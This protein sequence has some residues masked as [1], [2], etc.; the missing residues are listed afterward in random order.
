M[1]TIGSN[2]STHRLS[3]SG[4]EPFEAC[5]DGGRCWHNCPLV[6]GEP[7]GKGMPCW[8]VSNA[9]PLSGYGEDWTDADKALHAPKE[10]S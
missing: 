6:E 4:P 3:S 1:S 8:R 2:A 5:P 10:E 7:E 9:C